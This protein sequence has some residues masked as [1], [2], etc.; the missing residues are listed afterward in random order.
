MSFFLP[1]P[2]C[3]CCSATAATAHLLLL[4]LLLVLV[5]VLV[6]VLLMALALDDAATCCWLSGVTWRGVACRGVVPF[7]CSVRGVGCA[8]V[9]FRFKFSDAK[10]STRLVI[11]GW[12]SRCV[13][14]KTFIPCCLVSWSWSWSWSW[15]DSLLGS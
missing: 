6:L 3:R 8:R 14:E 10:V 4:F 5:L 7:A 1:P 2:P 13:L 9:V 15:T 12:C 11:I